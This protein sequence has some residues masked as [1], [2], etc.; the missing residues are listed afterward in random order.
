MKQAG[1]LHHRAQPGRICRVLGARQGL[2]QVSHHHS[3][4][5]KRRLRR[6]A[7]W[8]HDELL[9]RL[10]A[11]RQELTVRQ[12]TAQN[13]RGK[14]FTVSDLSRYI[15]HGDG[16]GARLREAGRLRRC[17]ARLNGCAPAALVPQQQQRSSQRRLAIQHA[18]ARPRTGFVYQQAQHLANNERR[19]DLRENLLPIDLQQG[20]PVAGTQYGCIERLPSSPGAQRPRDVLGALRQ[21]TV[22]QTRQLHKRAKFRFETQGCRAAYRPGK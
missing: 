11:L 16:H 5:L 3:R 9:Q 17:R 19:A 13:G 1:T 2:Q 18:Q 15:R 8:C 6:R 10:H 14:S 12:S 21:N 20:L 4:E 22:G 7:S